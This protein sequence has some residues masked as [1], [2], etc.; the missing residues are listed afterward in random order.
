M[1]T[2]VIENYHRPPTV[3]F[4]QDKEQTQL[5]YKNDVMRINNTYFTKLVR[6]NYVLLFDYQTSSQFCVRYLPIQIWQDLITGHISLVSSHDLM[7]IKY[8]STVD[9]WKPD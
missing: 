5:R 7:M 3:E 6:T 8:F 4:F 1:L 2:V 9:I